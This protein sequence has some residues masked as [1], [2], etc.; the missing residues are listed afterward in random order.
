MFPALMFA[1]YSASQQALACA[2]V[3]HRLCDASMHLLLHDAV[4]RRVRQW[5]VVH[6]PT[7]PQVRTRTTDEASPTTQ[8]I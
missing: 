2:A 4:A 3:D 6:K 1:M 8:L 7:K 5:P